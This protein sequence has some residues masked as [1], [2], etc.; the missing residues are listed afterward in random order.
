MS[1]IF[2]SRYSLANNPAP[3]LK[4]SRPPARATAQSA[5]SQ[6]RLLRWH[7]IMQMDVALPRDTCHCGTNSQNLVNRWR[8]TPCAASSRQ[9]EASWPRE[10][11][12]APPT[13][14]ITT[15]LG[16]CISSMH[17]GRP[18]CASPST[19]SCRRPQ[20]PATGPVRSRC[21]TEGLGALSLWPPT[22]LFI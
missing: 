6:A 12:S 9:M 11:P 10:A 8:D 3:P 14:T 7:F 21:G 5:Q 13:S 15:M 1:H 4:P 16:R 17:T 22:E 19:P 18:V 2:P 20:P